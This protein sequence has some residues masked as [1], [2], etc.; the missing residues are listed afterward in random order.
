VLGSTGCWCDILTFCKVAEM[1]LKT[2]KHTHGKTMVTPAVAQMTA[3]MLYAK[4]CPA[5]LV[6]VSVS[7]SSVSSLL[8]V[9]LLK[10]QVPSQSS[11]SLL[12]S[13]VSY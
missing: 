4:R 7:V 1:R 10:S 2:Y 6:S 12:K 3:T 11:L 9:C 13:Q 5:R 8:S